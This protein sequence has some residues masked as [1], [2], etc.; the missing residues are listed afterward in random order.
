MAKPVADAVSS[1]YKPPIPGLKLEELPIVDSFDD[2]EEEEAPTA[3]DE[4]ELDALLTGEPEEI[5][6]LSLDDLLEYNLLV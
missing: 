4:E 1:V 5:V 2:V 6:L 3:N